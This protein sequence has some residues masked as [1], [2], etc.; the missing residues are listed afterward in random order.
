M[1]NDILVIFC[2]LLLVQTAQAWTMSSFS[3]Q[4][5]LVTHRAMNGSRWT[6]GM[7]VKIRIVGRKGGSEKWLDEAYRMY[8]MRL[9][10]TN[11]DVETVWHKNDSDL[12]KAVSSDQEKG[13][14]IVLMD[15][16]GTMRSSEKFSRD[17]FSWLEAGGS[18]VVFV[19]GGANG[20]PLV[21]KQ[22]ISKSNQLSLSEMT[23]THQFSRTILMEQIYRASEIR[24]GT[25]YHK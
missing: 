18:R 8:E 17:L 20:L 6:M 2:A 19:I 23:F 16:T 7:G 14:T 22:Q 4:K 21:L 3:N 25:G 10:S 1:K 15:P 11:L 13:H 12:L 24:R 9:R 5:A